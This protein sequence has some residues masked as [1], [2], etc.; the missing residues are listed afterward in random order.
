[1]NTQELRGTAEYIITGE[2]HP[3]NGQLHSYLVD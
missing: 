1:V 3:P 2:G